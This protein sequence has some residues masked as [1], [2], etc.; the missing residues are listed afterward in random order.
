MAKKRPSEKA[1]ASAEKIL[2]KIEDV[3][4]GILSDVEKQKTITT[5]E[6]MK[7]LADA[8]AAE[9]QAGQPQ[10]EAVEH[11]TETGVT[12]IFPSTLSKIKTVDVLIDTLRQMIRLGLRDKK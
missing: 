4:P 5:Q 1:G 8:N 11:Q 6:L 7:L 9:E 10:K 3:M 2:E 12:E